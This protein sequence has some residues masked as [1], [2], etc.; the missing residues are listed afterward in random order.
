MVKCSFCGDRIPEG[1]GKI[2]VKNDGKILHFHGSKCHKNF[3]LGR[4][5]KRTGW[6]SLHKK[7]K[8]K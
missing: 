5:G 2:F 6:T 7:E 8:E 3:N 4:L 1:S